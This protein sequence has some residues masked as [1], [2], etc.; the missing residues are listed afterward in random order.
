MKGRRPTNRDLEIALQQSNDIIIQQK[1]QMDKIAEMVTQLQGE[2][3][4][5]RAKINYYENPNS[6]PSANSLA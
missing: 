2:N 6:P 1:S 3:E 4:Q 5:L